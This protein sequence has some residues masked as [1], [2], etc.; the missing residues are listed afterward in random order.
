VRRLLLSPHP[1]DAVWSCGGVLGDWT[2]QG[3]R[4]TVV[5]VF[6]GDPPPDNAG[7]AA[8][9][10][11]VRRREDSAALAYWPVS[12]LGLGLPDAVFRRDPAG[13]PLYAGPLAMRRGVHPADEPLAARVT[14]NLRPLLDDCDEV[15]LPLAAPSH[16]DHTIVREAAERALGSLARRRVR[17]YAEFPYSARAPAGLTAHRQPADFRAWLRVALVYRSQVTAIFGSPHRLA[18]ALFRHAH[19][20]DTPVWRSWTPTAAVT[21]SPRVPGRQPG[22]DA[23][24]TAGTDGTPSAAR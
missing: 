24:T 2:G 4:T 16:V 11:A 10:P 21:G 13:R 15:L 5:T 19:D 6:D 7:P 12:R 20:G 8:T 22:Y 3:D 17:Y 18:R 1:D 9:E 23:D 14:A